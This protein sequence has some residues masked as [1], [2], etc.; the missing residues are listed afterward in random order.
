MNY[1]RPPPFPVIRDPFRPRPVSR[2]RR[3]IILS[4]LLLLLA[5]TIIQRCEQA[6]QAAPPGSVQEL[7]PE[8]DYTHPVQCHHAGPPRQISSSLTPKLPRL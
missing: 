6:D 5:A 4:M 2:R 7:C 1:Y 8:P 3:L